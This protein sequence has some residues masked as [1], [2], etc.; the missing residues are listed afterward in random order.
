MKYPHVCNG[1][2]NFLSHYSALFGYLDGNAE[3]AKREWRRLKLFVIRDEVLSRLSYS[4]STSAS[5]TSTRAG[6]TTTATSTTSSSSSP[7][8][9][10]SSL[11]TTVCERSFSLMNS[12]KTAQR[13]VMGTKLLRILMALSS[14]GAEWR[15]AGKIPVDEIVEEWRSRSERGRYEHAM[16]KAAGLEEAGSGRWQQEQQGGATWTGEEDGTRAGSRCDGRHGQ[17]SRAHPQWQ[18]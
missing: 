18:R 14:L 3:K 4:C 2:G 11:T 12:L 16:W 17:S 9:A 10:A 1:S 5:S 6:R 13:S 15:D 8:L 7:S